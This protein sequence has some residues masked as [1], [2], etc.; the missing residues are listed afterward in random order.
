MSKDECEL[1]ATDEWWRA[2]QLPQP[3]QEIL[4]QVSSVVSQAASQA[5]TFASENPG[6]AA[7]VALPVFAGG[8]LAVWLASRLTAYSGNKTPDE[9]LYLLETTD[10]VLVDI[11]SDRDRRRQGLPVLEAGAYGKGAIIPRFALGSGASMVRNAGELQTDAV[12]ATIASLSKVRRRRTMVVLLD[13]GDG[14]AVP[15]AKRLLTFGVLNSCVVRGGFRQWT[16]DGLP[17][18]TSS[19][20]DY[21]VTALQLLGARTTFAAN[22]TATSLRSPELLLGSIASLALVVGAVLDWHQTLQFVGVTGL[23]LSVINRATSYESP[24][25]LI[26]DVSIVATTVIGPVASTTRVVG[27]AVARVVG[28][29]KQVS[30]QQRQQSSSSQ[31]LSR[32]ATATRGGIQAV[33]AEVQDVASEVA[34]GSPLGSDPA[35]RD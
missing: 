16:Q 34:S 23:L 6:G 1:P 10:A 5:A 31:Q 2:G 19:D 28:P 20:S 4:S 15:I 22:Q 8:P 3:V 14:T 17:V 30:Q 12:A 26:D 18:E 24:Q 7:A 9:V 21:A 29:S 35:A 33:A 32:G 13:Q 11:R 25:D 27:S